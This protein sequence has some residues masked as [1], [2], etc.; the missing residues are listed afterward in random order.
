MN[1][2][3]VIFLLTL[4][5]DCKIHDFLTFKQMAFSEKSIRVFLPYYQI[6][7]SQ[8]SERN[9]NNPNLVA[10]EGAIVLTAS[11]TESKIFPSCLSGTNLP[12]SLTKFLDFL[13]LFFIF[14]LSICTNLYLNC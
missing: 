4:F 1:L 14:A 12:N 3:V 11:S 6:L 9:E 5:S 7:V 10:T 8:V 2:K 13:I